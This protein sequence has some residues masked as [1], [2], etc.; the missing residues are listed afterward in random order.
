M[1]G[2]IYYRARFESVANEL[3]QKCTELIDRT[4][5]EGDI[6]RDNVDKV[7]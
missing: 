3:I 7:S 2:L 1:S 5:K 4:L 6:S